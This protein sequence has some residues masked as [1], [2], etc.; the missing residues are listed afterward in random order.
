MYTKTIRPADVGRIV[1]VMGCLKETNF[2]PM[3]QVEHPT[4]SI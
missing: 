4:E 2:I 1:F 3:K